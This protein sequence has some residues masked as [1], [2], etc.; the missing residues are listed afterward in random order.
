MAGFPGFPGSKKVEFSKKDI[1][2]CSKHGENMAIS[3]ESWNG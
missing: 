1:E 2:K 3:G